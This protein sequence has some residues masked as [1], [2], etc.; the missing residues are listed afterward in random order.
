MMMTMTMTTTTMMTKM[1]MTTTTMMTTMTMTMT[2]TPMRMRMT[3]VMMMSTISRPSL[4]SISEEEHGM[5]RL[6]ANHRQQV[7]FPIIR[8]RIVMM[9]RST[10][11]RPR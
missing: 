3:T 10:G 9:L 6:F 2:T 1:K 8:I 4:N 7:G 11:T 5:Q